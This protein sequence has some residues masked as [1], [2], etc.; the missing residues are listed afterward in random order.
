MTASSSA[1]KRPTKSSLAECNKKQNV[2]RNL[3]EDV[4]RIQRAGL[5]VQGGF[6][7]G[8]D[9]DTPSTFQRQIDFIQRSGIV[10]AMV[11][12]LQAPPATRLWQRMAEEGRLVGA[13]T[14]NNVEAATNII[15][16]MPL[17]TLYEGYREV[18]GHLYEPEHYYARAMTFLREVKPPKFSAP[19][20]AAYVRAFFRSMGRLGIVGKERAQYW[21]LFFWTLGRRPALLPLAITI[22]IYG[23]HFRLLAEAI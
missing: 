8:F 7:L 16:K 12:L 5:E 18:V 11:G 6:I 10:T 17:E 1:S 19:I 13:L 21:K 9:S 3:V 15:P 2:G 23:Y 22:A 14:G 20:D 4:K